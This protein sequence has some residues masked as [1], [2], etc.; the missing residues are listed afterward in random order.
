MF[1]SGR[2]GQICGELLSQALMAIGLCFPLSE[3]RILAG[4]AGFAESAVWP[5][6]KQRRILLID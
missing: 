5:T 6:A 4:L 2:S 3:P 1:K